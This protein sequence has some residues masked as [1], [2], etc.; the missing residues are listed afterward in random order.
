MISELKAQIFGTFD[1]KEL[2]DAKYILQMGIRIDQTHISLWLSQINYVDTILQRF[3]MHECKPI[4]IPFRF[5]MK[6]SLDMCPY[7]D[8]DI[9]DMSMVP[10]ASVVGGLIYGMV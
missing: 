8:D 1:M 4:S 7:F 2:R 6:L 5:G 3:N 10:Y 9:E